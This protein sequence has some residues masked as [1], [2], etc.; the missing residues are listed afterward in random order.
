[1]GE[2]GKR[3]FRLAWVCLFE[4]ESC[5]WAN[6]DLHVQSAMS[7]NLWSSSLH[8]PSSDYTT[9]ASLCGA[10]DGNQGFMFMYAKHIPYKLSSSICPTSNLKIHFFCFLRL[11]YIC[12]IFPFPFLPLN[13]L[14]GPPC[15]F[16]FMVSFPLVVA[17][18]IWAYA[19]AYIS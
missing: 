6:F 19:C 10:R 17:V 12:I 1:M 8:L 18:Y 11:Q 5:A 15:S 14:Y 16:K 4:I 13:L 9:K 2:V 3:H 7:L